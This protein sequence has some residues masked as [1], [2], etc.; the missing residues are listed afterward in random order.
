M[1]I[2]NDYG[3]VVPDTSDRLHDLDKEVMILFLIRFPDIENNTEL[4][5][6]F[7][8]FKFGLDCRFSEEILIR[9]MKQRKASRELTLVRTSK[10]ESVEASLPDE[11]MGE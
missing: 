1:K 5:I 9:A 4:R 8:E 11:P 7:H 6:L 3:M 2:Y 10:I